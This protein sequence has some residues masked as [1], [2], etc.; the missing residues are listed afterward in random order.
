M[1]VSYIIE[2]MYNGDD[3]DNATT[4]V[5]TTFDDVDEMDD[6][7]AKIIKK[8]KKKPTSE[9]P[10]R[11]FIYQITT[12]KYGNETDRTLHGWSDPV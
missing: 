8:N 11:I 10:S 9:L 5:L 1:E 12:D 3:N 2:A 6:I 7:L 4:A